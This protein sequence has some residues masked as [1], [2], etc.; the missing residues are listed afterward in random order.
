MREEG[1]N[2]YF[3]FP[4]LILGG[5]FFYL[6]HRNEKCCGNRFLTIVLYIGFSLIFGV[7]FMVYV[8]IPWWIPNYKGGYLLP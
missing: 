4:I 2:K 6:Y 5:L 8:F 3:L 7:A 1:R